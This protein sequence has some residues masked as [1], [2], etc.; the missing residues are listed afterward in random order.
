MSAIGV[1][2]FPIV[3]AIGRGSGLNNQSLIAN[4]AYFSLGLTLFGLVLAFYSG[5]RI[6]TSGAWNGSSETASSNSNIIRQVFSRPR[7]ARLLLLSALVYGVFYASASGMIVFRPSS[8]FSEVYHVTVPSLAV[9]TCCEPVGQTP[10]MVAYVTQHLG[11]LIVPGN[12]VLLFVLS[13]L[14]GLNASLAT[15]AWSLQVR[16]LGVSW[17]GGLGAFVGLFTSC[18][19]C[20]GLAVLS[21]LGGTG[22]LSAGFFLGPFQTLLIGLSM[23]LLVIT[24][25][26]LTR[27]LKNLQF[28]ACRIA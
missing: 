5:T 10:E 3:A 26:L 12:L 22:T 4:Y 1:F 27:R 15:Y 2:S 18:P 25:V 14:V 9:A 20:A 21:L 16:D 23:P 28:Q 19:T 8:N 17:V 6:L 24:P 13:W 7:Y 11:V